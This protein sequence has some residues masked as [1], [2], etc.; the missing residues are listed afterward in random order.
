MPERSVLKPF[1]ETII[2]AI[3]NCHPS[4]SDGAIFN[5]LNLVRETMIPK[6]HDEII[7]AIDKY[8]DFPGSDKYAR[9]IRLVKE[10]LLAQKTTYE[11]ASAVTIDA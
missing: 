7:A 4:P 5:L 2:T 9:D 11:K 6:G 8:F 10:S 3:R 1:H